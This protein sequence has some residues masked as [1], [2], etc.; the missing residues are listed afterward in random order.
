M[1]VE[2]P[3]RIPLGARVRALR[4]SRGISQAD[5]ARQI[6]ISASYLNLLEHNQRNFTNAILLKLAKA[7]EIE[8][9][10]IVEDE[11]ARLTN[12]M[13]DIF[14]DPMFG[15]LDIDDAEINELGALSANICRAIRTLYRRYKSVEVA[16][17]SLVDRLAESGARL[18]Q[19]RATSAVLPF[20]EINDF[21]QERHNH[22]PRLEEAA[23]ALRERLDP[24]FGYLY[25][26][27]A[28]YAERR[29][30][31]KVEFLQPTI[32]SG[33]LR[34]LEPEAGRI[35]MNEVLPPSSRT[36]QLAHQIALLDFRELIDEL[37]DQATLPDDPTCDLARIALAN[38]IAGAVMMPYDAFIDAARSLRYDLDLLEHRFLAS[39]EQVCH[40]L[41]TLGRPGNA[42][43]PLHFVRVDIAGN[44]SKRFSASGLSIARYSAGCPRWNVHRAFLAP[45]RLRVQLS[46]MPD[47]KS[48]L[49]VSRAVR[50][51]GGGFIHGQSYLSIGIGCEKRF[52]DQMI[53][54]DRIV[55]DDPS[56]EVPIGVSCRSCERLSC[57]QRA[58]PPMHRK[59]SHDPSL[60][61][62][63]AYAIPD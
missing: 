16:S 42:G 56:I 23:D 4:H 63:S 44:I 1:S 59:V 5:L 19:V 9:N 60:R 62:F 58:A 35:V 31:L 25:G 21:F 37:V 28:N 43:I 29:H 52:A 11:T 32:L 13:A 14:S 41:T 36:F 38:Y 53:Y 15:Q 34:K 20:E 8:V 46:T 24:S 3:R 17:N 26:Q 55:L 40:R 7:L 39:F 6:D 10:Q 22:F 54:G 12:E 49:C 30:G 50:K 61:A 18:Q 27:L 45:N 48:Y 51:L 33:V 2:D 57:A 47:G